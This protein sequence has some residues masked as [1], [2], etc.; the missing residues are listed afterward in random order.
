LLGGAVH[1]FAVL[2]CSLRR[3]DKSLGQMARE[4][5]GKMGGFAPDAI[6]I[7]QRRRPKSFR[8]SK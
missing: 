2:F 7:E 1:D 8:Q 6:P 3:N 5:I 4:E